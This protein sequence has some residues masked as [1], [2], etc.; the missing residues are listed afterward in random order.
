MR[1][2]NHEVFS[3]VVF[4]PLKVNKKEDPDQDRKAL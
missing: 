4:L 3:L 1:Q 2:E